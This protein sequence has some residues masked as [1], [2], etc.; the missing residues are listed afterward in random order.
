MKYI[1][2]CRK[3]TDEKDKQVLSIDQQIS[4]LK[5]FAVRDKLE[6]V[7]FVIEAKTAKAPGREQFAE[8]LK[9]IEAGEAQGIVSW[10]PDRLARNSIDGGKIIYLLDTGKLK[11]LK[12]PTF[13]FES[14]PQGKFM[15]NIAFGQSKY[16]VDNLSENTKRGLHYKLKRGIWP[17]KAPYGYSNNPKT[18][19]IDIDPVESKVIKKAFEMFAKGDVSFVEVTRFLAKF[20]IKGRT[21]K[22]IKIEQLKKGV[23]TNPFYIG[24]MKYAGEVVEGKHQIFISK[25]LFNR[26]QKQIIRIEKPRKGS[27]SNHFAF[28]GIARCGEC[29]AAITA[30]KH[31]K[32]YKNGN[33]QTFIYY[34]CTKKLIPCSQKYVQD[35]ELEEQL[36]KQML[37]LA[38]PNN[39]QND[40]EKWLEKDKTLEEEKAEENIKKLEL[41]VKS[42][43]I[44]LNLLL[45]GYLEGT[46]E[47]ESYKA[48]KN[49]LFEKKLLLEDKIVMIKEKGSSWLEPFES[50]MLTAFQARK[51]V[52]DKNNCEELKDFAKSAGSNFILTNRQLSF[53]PNLGWDS[54][55]SVCARQASRTPTASISDSVPGTGV[56]P[57]RGLIPT[58][59]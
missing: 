20:G 48:K 17:T 25:D 18:R 1:A 44:K 46:I 28:S 14:T 22:L 40:W 47:A 43:E 52:S 59:F 12:F 23:L 33:S 41:E 7:E 37:K 10:H 35:Q 39:W 58:W 11:D 19:E 13:W 6:I 27:R 38:L 9:K 15:L 16:Y 31:T 32:I 42:L 55:F 53:T 36:R 54:V 29:G 51:I 3:S 34:R 30:E 21:D 5:E 4:S 45:D 24:I 57:A 8:V 2:Y 50:F 26:V 56:E 49:E